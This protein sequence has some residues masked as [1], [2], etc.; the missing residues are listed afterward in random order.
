MLCNANLQRDGHRITIV[1]VCV[2]A[3]AYVCVCFRAS[4]CARVR[5]RENMCVVKNSLSFD[6][7]MNETVTMMNDAT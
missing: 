7:L 1:C 5:V 6:C 3:F 4:A 2:L